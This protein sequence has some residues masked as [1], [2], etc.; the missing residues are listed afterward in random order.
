MPSH[1]RITAPGDFRIAVGSDLVS[2]TL[3]VNTV[4]TNPNNLTVDPRASLTV[5][6]MTAAG[7]LELASLGNLTVLGNLSTLGGQSIALGAVGDASIQGSLI[8]KDYP[9]TLR[10][11]GNLDL[12][13]TDTSATNFRF[14]STLG[15]AITL[16]SWGNHLRLGT[17]IDT[18][19]L[20]ANNNAGGDIV[21]IAHQGDLQVT[22][23]LISQNKG[24]GLS[25]IWL[26]SLEGDVILSG[27][28]INAANAKLNPIPPDFNSFAG[29]ILVNANGTITLANSSISTAGY[30]GRI[31]MGTSDLS[32]DFTDNAD[33]LADSIQ[34]SNSTIESSNSIINGVKNSGAIE[35]RGG[36]IEI[37]NSTVDTSTTGEGDAG[38]ITI[39]ATTDLSL[40][41]T[42]IE[43]TT[44]G[45]GSASLIT[46]LAGENLNLTNAS[47]VSSSTVKSGGASGNIQLTG[48]NINVTGGSVVQA[49]SKGTE[50]GTGAPGNITATFTGAMEVSGMSL[51]GQ[52]SELSTSSGA[53]A[54][55]STSQGSITINA[56]TGTLT[57]DNRGRINALTQST[58]PNYQGGAI[59][60]LVNGLNIQGGSQV[61]ATS[62]G[63][64]KAGN[65][66]INANRISIDGSAPS[67]AD[68]LENPVDLSEFVNFFGDATPQFDGSTLSSIIL[69][70][71]VEALSVGALQNALNITRIPNSPTG[72]SPTEGSGVTFKTLGR[73]LTAD[74]QF[75]SSDRLPHEDF[76]FFASG[77]HGSVAL[78]ANAFNQ[79][80]K[81]TQDPEA[82]VLG[83]I[84]AQGD[85]LSF[86]V[87]DVKDQQND[88]S[89]TLRNIKLD[90]LSIHAI[91]PQFDIQ[92]TQPFTSGIF[93][94][95]TGSG[96]AGS[97]TLNAPTIQL[98]NQGT[99]SASTL[100]GG[101]SSPANINLQQVRTLELT[102]SQILA[103][104]A[105]GEAGSIFINQ[106]D[107]PLPNLI[108]QGNSLISVA[109][110]TVTQDGQETA[111]LIQINGNQVTLTGNTGGRSVI[112]A[113][114]EKGSSQGIRFQNLRN[115]E[116]TQGDIVASTID[117]NAPDLRLGSPDLILDRIALQ[118][119]TLSVAATGFGNSGQLSLYTRAL[120]ATQN[121]LISASTH[122]GTSD[123]ILLPSLRT[124]DLLDSRIQATTIQGVAGSVIMTA[125]DHI[126]AQGT[127]GD[128]SAAGISVQAT[129]G[130]KA[131][132]I[133]LNTPHLRV[134]HGAVISAEAGGTA[135]GGDITL[136]PG[137]TGDH[138]A[139]DFANH[140][141]I[142]A[143]TQGT[144][145]GGSL[146][147]TAP[148]SVTIRGLGQVAV[149][150]SG[151]GNAGRILLTTQDFS[152]MDGAILSGSTS[153]RGNAGAIDLTT[154]RLTLTDQARIQSNTSAGGQAGDI[155][156]TTAFF[157]LSQGAQVL[158]ETRGPGAGGTVAIHG[159]SQV[160]LGNSPQ[161]ATPIISVKTSGPGRAGNIQIST[162]EFILAASGEITATATA[163]ATTPERGGSI[164]IQANTLDLAGVV[165]VFA[166][167]QGSTPAGTLS[168]SSY[169]HSPTLTATFAQGATIS[170]S[171]AGGGNGG[172]FFITAPQAI[173]LR[174]VGKLAVETTGTGNAGTFE[175]TT[176]NLTLSDGIEVSAS[177]YSPG[178]QAG[179]AGDIQL[180]STNLTLSRGASVR[181]NTFG[182]GDSGNIKVNTT[183]ILDI[184]GGSMEATT[185]LGSTG[186]GGNIDID[187]TDTYLRQG[188]RIA[189]DSQGTGTGGSIRLVSDNLYLDNGSISAVTRSSDG[190]NIT[191]VLQNV[192]RMVNGSYIS[193]EA[194]TASSGGNG[195]DL[196]IKAQFVIAG[197]GSNS[198]MI[199]N[200]F[201]GNGGSINIDALGIFGFDVRNVNNPRQ[202][203]RNNL[204][205]SSRF[206]T[207]GTV[208]ARSIDLSQGL[209]L[210]PANLIDPSRLIDR[211]CSLASSARQSKFTIAGRGGL[212]LG[213]HSLLVGRTITL[214][215]RPSPSD[216]G[217][218][219]L[220]FSRAAVP[221]ADP[222]A[223]PKTLLSSA[224]AIAFAP[225]GP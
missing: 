216:A 120:T 37:T 18:T 56:P 55:L 160:R 9:I 69:S 25:R 103:S 201:E 114:T 148:Q 135:E 157:N 66:L 98:S 74:W 52:L 195:G 194:G 215:L 91:N 202:N 60:I 124:L 71:G 173:I 225:C 197:S 115:L 11:K 16:E 78:L 176:E 46:L 77:S 159:S 34:I 130:G 199:A 14:V 188:G 67:F 121:S 117:G 169:R 172:D 100:S 47:S 192:L 203:P 187:P 12:S 82:N 143:S 128:G 48:Q 8:T 196:R 116:I 204:T 84:T 119:G 145:A 65:I 107:A 99:I 80:A 221:E 206:G 38:A 140:G 180:T 122:W 95:A 155:T 94:Q 112:S 220:G 134:A 19:Y 35:I 200:A 179:R 211:S 182:A 207:S 31:V 209:I 185:G 89:L 153:S 59:S 13:R 152:L 217:A 214:D 101:F 68:A 23:R 181:T 126:A 219:G 96:S 129:Q 21:A 224:P 222:E 133:T 162:P 7:N 33:P 150:T 144:Q 75:L 131:G 170:A 190:G 61:L 86:G 175:I 125:L 141:S 156:L 161:E 10:S 118:D 28:R 138:L 183:R 22:S 40:D 76:G 168:L 97:V 64:A 29:D 32:I 3:G 142:T 93:V 154:S 218:L 167:T 39:A 87:V 49:V 174:G 208:N 70:S 62:S 79:Q 158:A 42:S 210:L 24:G 17:N 54:N 58:N 147:I 177:T 110:K 132:G 123:S 5:G 165:G 20:G 193:T 139:I 127:L 151:A 88:A 184:D 57:L 90:G 105:T 189:V 4:L 26:E 27:A 205:A 43:G 53:N 44:N 164:S 85:A 111:G 136:Q 30:G 213:P 83:S 108:L 137:L 2:G 223:I 41:R 166:E 15:G 6:A 186:N 102:D 106:N 113:A 104:T 109:A 92:L 146:F 36:A 45:T 163:T 198:D 81:A 149:E 1:Y 212:T 73:T 51:F 50:T 191:L 63:A 171:T 178:A 72:E